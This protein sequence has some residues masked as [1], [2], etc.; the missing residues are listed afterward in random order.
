MWPGD[1]PAA[2]A[3]RRRAGEALG[4]R[5]R[6]QLA[7]ELLAGGDALLDGGL[8]AVGQARHLLGDEVLATLG[9]ALDVARLALDARTAAADDALGVTAAPAQLAL[10]ARARLLGLALE[11]VALGRAAAL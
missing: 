6:R 11:A 7:G 3:L 8:D 9:R 1:L 2:A 5:A 4:L 10:D